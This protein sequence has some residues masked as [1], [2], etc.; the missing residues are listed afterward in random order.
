ME[1]VVITKVIV[2]YLH[3]LGMGS[4]NRVA[5][6]LSIVVTYVAINSCTNMYSYICSHHSSQAIVTGTPSY[7]GSISINILLYKS[8]IASLALIDICILGSWIELK[9]T[10]LMQSDTFIGSLV[11]LYR[12]NHVYMN[13]SNTLSDLCTPVFTVITLISK[14][15]HQCTCS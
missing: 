7:I 8:S 9:T 1:A 12:N 6:L 14:A 2:S 5:S 11:R 4:R 13:K 15:P 10:V 3:V